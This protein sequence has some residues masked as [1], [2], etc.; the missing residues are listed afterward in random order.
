[1]KEIYFLVFSILFSGVL[2]VLGYFLRTVHTEFK[3]LL[4]ELTEYT[5]EL[6]NLISGIQV[7]IDKGIEADIIDLKK[8][9]KTLYSKVN[10][11]S[12]QISKLQNQSSQ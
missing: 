6:R 2:A 3:T 8:D 1:M 4:K 10:V 11:Q 5:Q 12:A 7:Q 9:V